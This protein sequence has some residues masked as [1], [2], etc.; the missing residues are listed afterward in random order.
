MNKVHIK[1]VVDH[2]QLISLLR[3]TPSLSSAIPV[4]AFHCGVYEC[5]TIEDV[6][7]LAVETVKQERQAAYE[8]LKEFAP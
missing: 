8:K 1:V 4:A 5:E 3:A 2:Q 6:W 7:G